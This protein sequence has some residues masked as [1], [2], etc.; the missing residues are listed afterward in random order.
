MVDNHK[1]TVGLLISSFLPNL[2]GIEV[3]LHNIALRV[4]KLGW[5][6]I[7]FAP[8]EHVSALKKQNWNLPYEVVALPP[9]SWG[10]IT[11]WPSLGFKIMDCYLG[12]MQKKY[13]V[14]F[15]HVT[16]GYPMGCAMVHYDENTK[17]E[18]QYL[19]RCAGEDIQRKPDIG[20]GLRLI[21]KFDKV[22]ST[23]LSRA[24]R[25]VAITPS[26]YEEY[27][28]L[29][30]DDERIFNIPNGVAIDRF[31]KDVDRAKIR[32]WLG[33]APTDTMILCVGRNHPKKNYST[34][35]K[36][37]RYLL[38]NGFK[39]FKIVCVG[40]GCQNLSQVVTEFGLEDH[41]ILINGL[42]AKETK[43]IVLPAQ[44][45]VEVYKSSDIFAFP[46][47]TETFGIAI[48]EAMAAGLPVIVGDSE[49][50]RDIVERGRW[51][52]MCDPNSA[53]DL[54]NKILSVYNDEKLRNS[55]ISKSKER[56]QYFDWDTIAQKYVS[57]YKGAP[58]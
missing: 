16:M 5:T 55:L 46:S 10:V 56:A 49:G 51:G 9:K 14:D 37:G 45:L 50:C 22:I 25:L 23:Y 28:S 31:S 36:A 26:V 40:S 15:W 19:I 53:E 52:L 8:Y 21:P 13:G 39:D 17:A 57:I 48:V 54:A 30:V 42:S 41:V 33:V 2:G 47:F 58:T 1:K 18:I 43:D 6:P 12:H 11:R 27:K 35:L 4:E 44:E 34:L 38:D 20:Y 3:G 32:E 29:N 7:V 24:K